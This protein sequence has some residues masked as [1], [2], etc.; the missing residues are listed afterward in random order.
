MNMINQLDSSRM[1]ACRD[2]LIPIAMLLVACFTHSR[3]NGAGGTN[4]PH[5]EPVWLRY[6]V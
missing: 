4:M 2:L 6:A 3:V 1:I 5:G